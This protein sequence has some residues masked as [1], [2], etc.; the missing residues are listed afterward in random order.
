MDSENA[1]TLK[2]LGQLISSSI[3]T[4]SSIQDPSKMA[5]NGALNGTSANG[6]NDTHTAGSTQDFPSREVFDLQRNLLAAAGKLTELT[7]SPS[8]RLLEV[9]SQY[10]EARALHIAADKR[11]PDILS[12]AAG[13]SLHISAL[14]AKVGIEPRKLCMS[15]PT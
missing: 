6:A 14:A 7:S 8:S 10:F 15:F 11:I 1:S 5:S 4:L 2:A 9:S 3:E 12:N 13:G